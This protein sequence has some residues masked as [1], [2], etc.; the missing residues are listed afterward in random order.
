MRTRGQSEGG[1][2]WTWHAV[3]PHCL[4]HPKMGSK[5]LRSMWRKPLEK[6]KKLHLGLKF[7][8]LRWSLHIFTDFGT[9]VKKWVLNIFELNRNQIEVTSAEVKKRQFEAQSMGILQKNEKM[10]K[11]EFQEMLRRYK[12]N[13]R[14]IEWPKPY[15]WLTNNQNLL[16]FKFYL[17]SNFLWMGAFPAAI[18]G[19]RKKTM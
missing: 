5:H 15:Y 19:I 4:H 10:P 13:C 11:H 6:L 9:H 14:D 2:K 12:F 3:A 16:A 1:L 18:P 7:K 17:L 8:W